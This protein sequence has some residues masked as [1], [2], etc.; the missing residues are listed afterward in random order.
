MQATDLRG[1]AAMVI[2]AL[3]A[4]GESTIGAIEHIDRG[5]EHIERVLSGVGGQIERVRREAPEKNDT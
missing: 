5:Y 1:G 4:E 3:A 2:A